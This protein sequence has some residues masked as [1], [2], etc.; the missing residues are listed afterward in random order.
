[1]TSGTGGSAGFNPIGGGFGNAAG[2]GD[3]TLP[4][5]ACE[6]VSQKAENK[7]EPADIIFALD[8]SGSMTEESVW[9]QEN[10]NGFSTQIINANVDAHVIVISSY[11][12]NKNGVCIAGPLGSGGCPIKDTNLPGFLHV[13]EVVS[14]HDAL[15]LIVSTY[16]RYKSALRAGAIKHIVVVTDDESDV[17]AAAFTTNLQSLD[18]PSFDGFKFHGIFSYTEGIND[19]CMGFSA[20]E[21]KI[22]RELVTQTGGISGDLC[23]QDFK[24]V[25]DR[26]AESVVGTSK[27]SCEWTIPQPPPGNTFDATKTNVTYTGGGQTPESVPHVDSV[28]ACQTATNGWAWFY[29][30]GAHPTKIK[31][32]ANACDTIQKD[33]GAKIDIYFGCPT[34][35]AIPR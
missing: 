19:Q 35:E 24:P 30:D 5:A 9:V 33:A 22:Y 26:L 32:C 18:P 10:M 6:A 34:V 1:V 12:G 15:E 27:L 7:A 25:F 28:G 13:D 2:S 8:N 16:P 29:D 21:G 23:L 31:V 11:P 4:D 3:T 20:G 14:S 17:A